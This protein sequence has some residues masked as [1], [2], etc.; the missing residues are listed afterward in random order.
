MPDVPSDTYDPLQPQP[1]WSSNC[2]ALLVATFLIL[3]PTASSDERDIELV[4]AP[5]WQ[6]SLPAVT[7]PTGERSLRE[8]AT[9][10]TER[11]L[12]VAYHGP[13][14]RLALPSGLPLSNVRDV[15][16]ALCTA[17][18]MVWELRPALNG[19]PALVLLDEPLLLSCVGQAGP[20]TIIVRAVVKTA[21]GLQLE[22]WVEPTEPGSR[23][24]IPQA[25][26][27]LSGPKGR[28]SLVTLQQGERG[29]RWRWLL[30][31][32]NARLPDPPLRLE[33]TLSL[34]APLVLQRL[35]LALADSPAVHQLGTLSRHI[36]LH[37]LRR[38]DAHHGEPL[39]CVYA[40]D[41]RL[42]LGEDHAERWPLHAAAFVRNHERL[43]IPL[44]PD[45]ALSAAWLPLRA[46]LG[47]QQ[48]LD[49]APTAL[50]LDIITRHET[51]LE[52]VRLPLASPA[53]QQPPGISGNLVLT[54]S[55]GTAL[56]LEI[57]AIHPTTSAIR[58]TAVWV[59]LAQLTRWQAAGLQTPAL[60]EIN[61][62]GW[63]EWSRQRSSYHLTLPPGRWLTYARWRRNALLW[64][65]QEVGDHGGLHDWI[66][67]DDARATLHGTVL[68]H[69]GG[70]PAAPDRLLQL[71]PLD[72]QGREPH[73]GALMITTR[74]AVDGAFRIEHLMP[75]RYCVRYENPDLP[76]QP[77]LL[78]KQ[79][80]IE[81][82]ST[83]MRTYRLP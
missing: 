47:P 25:S 44:A 60:R 70:P 77:I 1:A 57:G 2:R 26:W 59:D 64:R 11:G 23:F 3:I 45:S 15:L 29:G 79:L 41:V 28:V 67:D 14:R 16:L 78:E 68:A 10:L 21:A 43:V 49:P 63:V 13:P 80:P 65:V 32:D 12:P 83:V 33:L 52:T 69:D 40:C 55:D 82:A 73:V 81:R 20:M 75:G 76:W 66:L 30:A 72:E 18:D 62:H 48:P 8:W 34:T 9:W 71:T 19:E 22:V 50:E 37:A 38:L 39:G 42:N 74:V 17:G 54:P 61:A 51:R 6:P 36:T 27:R 35:R 31:A 58:S 7:T 5:R 56:R 4:L 46:A 24:N 53:E